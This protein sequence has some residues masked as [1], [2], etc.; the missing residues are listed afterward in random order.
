VGQPVPTCG[1]EVAGFETVQQYLISFLA[2]DTDSFGEVAVHPS[3]MSDSAMYSSRLLTE[4]ICVVLYLLFF[5]FF[6]LI[7]HFNFLYASVLNSWY[8]T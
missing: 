2:N 5:M 3:V 4:V 6:T 8:L 7:R 1:E